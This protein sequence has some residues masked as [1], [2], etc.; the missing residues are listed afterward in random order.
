MWQHQYVWE[1][2]RDLERD[3]PSRDHRPEKPK[4]ARVAAGV[5]RMTG[6][7]L[8]RVG[9]GLESWATAPNADSAANGNATAG[10]PLRR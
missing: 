9:E 6:R 5:M 1:K 3:R 8:C 7:L 2:L 4:K 10:E